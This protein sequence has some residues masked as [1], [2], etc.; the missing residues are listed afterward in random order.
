M[1]EKCIYLLLLAFHIY[2]SLLKLKSVVVTLLLRFKTNNF[3]RIILH[4][5]VASKPMNM[6]R[7]KLPNSKKN[8]G[9]VCIVLTITF[10]FAVC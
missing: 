4:P 5:L 7:R 9:F 10:C 1:K 6:K 8:E 2:Y 3:S